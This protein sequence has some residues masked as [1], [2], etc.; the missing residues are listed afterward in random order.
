MGLHEGDGSPSKEIL[1]EQDTFGDLLVENFIDSYLNL[2]LKSVCILKYI[3]DK[4]Q[5]TKF[6]V[7]ADDDVF[8]HIPNLL[9]TLFQ[10]SLPDK[11]V[12]GAAICGV[13]PFRNPW[14]KYYSPTHMFNTSFYPNYASGTSYVL[15]GNIVTDL[16]HVALQTPL[17]HME[18][19]FITGICAKQLGIGVTDDTG[20]SPM[21]RTADPCLYQNVTMN[22]DMSP[23]EMQKIWSLLLNKNAMLDCKPLTIERLRRY[24]HNCD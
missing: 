3:R 2:T 15:S 16:Y 4:C 14:N 7:K 23:F 21:H 13:K 9:R 18:D 17:F 24:K 22:H 6:V 8:L 1:R 11:L 19:V 10:S 5:S 12:L 20:F